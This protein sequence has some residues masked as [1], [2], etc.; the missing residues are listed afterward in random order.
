LN[1]PNEIL[2]ELKN[3]YE[4]YFSAFNEYATDYYQNLLNYKK[5]LNKTKREHIKDINLCLIRITNAIASLMESINSGQ[6]FIIK[7]TNN[8][9]IDIAGIAICIISRL[10]L[11]P[12][13]EKLLIDRDSGFTAYLKVLNDNVIHKY[14]SIHEHKVYTIKEA[15]N[16]SIQNIPSDII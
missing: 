1:N 9:F 8:I 4:S 15:F 13:K 7:D 11:L 6:K 10:D 16:I 14:N 12:E 5:K 2:I 3:T